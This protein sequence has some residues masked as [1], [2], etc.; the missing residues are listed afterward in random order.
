MKKHANTAKTIAGFGR[1]VLARKIPQLASS[2]SLNDIYNYLK[3]D[4]VYSTSGQPNE[5]QFKLISNAGYK[6]VVNL[7]PTSKLENSIV[8]ERRILSDLGLRYV[9]IPVDFMN[10]TEKDFQSFVDTVDQQQDVWV[11]CAANMRVSAFTYRYRTQV[12]GESTARAEGD[13]RKIW[14]PL[15]VWADFIQR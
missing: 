5:A 8:E 10:P 9:H 12:L 15:G 2:H 14:E 6:L 3:I 4:G 7:A 11:H 13:L 1:S